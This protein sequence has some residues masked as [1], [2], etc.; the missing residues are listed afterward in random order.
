[1]NDKKLNNFE[2]PNLNKLQAVIIDHKT[3]IYIAPNADPEEAR[4]RYL[5]RI[6]LK[7]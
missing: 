2:S 7:R 1:M 6:Y 4:N 3:T 5:S